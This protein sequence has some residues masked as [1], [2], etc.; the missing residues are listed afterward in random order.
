MKRDWKIIEKILTELES[1]VAINEI[2]N[3]DDLTRETYHL[4]LDDGYILSDD[5]SDFHVARLTT[6]GH[7]LLEYL[8]YYN[9]K[10]SEIPQTEDIMKTY[11]LRQLK[12]KKK[13]G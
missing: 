8:R 1:E 6:K 13:K 2:I 5:K 7:D 10:D 11:F 4:L 9:N 3:N 12:K